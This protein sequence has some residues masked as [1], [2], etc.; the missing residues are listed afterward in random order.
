[1]ESAT[2]QKLK[3]GTFV[4][5]SV[6]LFIF[7]V[8]MIGGDK[9][10]FTS[11][12]RLKVHFNQV[13]GLAP[14]SVVSL[15]GV[16]IGNVKAIIFAPD[17]ESVQVEMSI[18]QSFQS[19]ITKSSTAEI[20]TQGALGD[21]YVYITPGNPSD[22]VLTTGDSIKAVDDGD[23]LTILS[24]E[25]DTFREIFAIIKEV[26]TVVRNMNE[27]GRSA[28]IMENLKDVSSDLKLLVHEAGLLVK[29]VRKGGTTAH[30]LSKS[31]RSLASVMEKIDSGNGS[32]GALVNDPSLHDRLTKFL[33]GEPRQKYLKNLIRKSIQQSEREE[34]QP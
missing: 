5:I 22:P 34:A 13:Q 32:L 26:H 18:E 31:V 25:G 17:K 30:D 19:K 21:K 28:A 12:Y 15:S 9:A 4:F 10:L 20:R 23:L 2:G 6:V 7:T 1:M 33:G 8:F 16:P 3:V 27:G 29:E 14:G 11:Y 24:N